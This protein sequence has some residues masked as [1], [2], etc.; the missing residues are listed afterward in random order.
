M[1]EAKKATWLL[2]SSSRIQLFSLVVSLWLPSQTWSQQVSSNTDAKKN[3]VKT[4]EKAMASVTQ[5]YADELQK[6]SESVVVEN[7]YSSLAGWPQPKETWVTAEFPFDNSPSKNQTTTLANLAR[8]ELP[9]RMEG[10]DITFVIDENRKAVLLDGEHSLVFP[11]TGNFS[12]T[13]EFTICL[14][15]KVPEHLNRAVVLHRTKSRIAGGFIGYELLIEKGHFRFG[16]IH[17][18]PSNAIRIH[19]KDPVPLAKW[20]HVA[21]VYGGT[22]SAR[23]T[24]IYIDGHRA[25]VD[26]LQ[27]SLQN[28]F[29]FRGDDGLL[30]IGAREKDQGLVGGLVARLQVYEHALTGIEIAGLVTD[31]PMVTWGEWSE[32]QRE[33]W[34]EHY[35]RREDAQCRYHV[36][37]FRHYFNTLS[38]ILGES[39]PRDHER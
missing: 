38:E 39:N 11:K 21:L 8:P 29:Q 1:V 6:L 23:N 25:E 14:E 12:R 32:Q 3:R 5:A 2:A 30:S 33:L 28:D 15:L 24:C 37:S 18:E 20:M 27:D 35:A 16:L 17:S 19:C 4:L 10:A 34:R 36:E 22:N 13:E 26:I 7:W 9:G 31:T